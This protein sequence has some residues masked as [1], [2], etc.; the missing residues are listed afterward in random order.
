LYVYVSTLPNIAVFATGGTIAGAAAS[1]S[2]TTT[3]TSG[4]VG[5]AALVEAVPEISSI[6]NIQG[7][8]VNLIAVD[9]MRSAKLNSMSVLR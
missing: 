9:F 3:Y 1:S 7:V 6:A 2:D 5:I 4:V 8:Q